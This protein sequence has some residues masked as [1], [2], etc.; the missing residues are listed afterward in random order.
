VG[1]ADDPGQ[2]ESDSA[3]H[4]GVPSEGAR[5]EQL[6]ELLK[7]EADKV[8]ARGSYVI[9]EGSAVTNRRIAGTQCMRRWCVEPL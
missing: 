9:Y 2:Q 8:L 6:P 7:S 1:K 5:V 4:G 3:Q